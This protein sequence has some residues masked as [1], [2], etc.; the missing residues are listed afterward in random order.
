MTPRRLSPL[1]LGLSVVAVGCAQ[2]PDPFAAPASPAMQLHYPTGLALHPTEPILFVANSNFDLAYSSGAVLGVHL[3]WLVQTLNAQDRVDGDIKAPFGAAAL[4]PSIG[5][6]LVVSL[7]GK[8]LFHTTRQDNKLV[9]LTV[10]AREDGVTL[11]CV[12]GAGDP[13]DCT[14]GPH[15]YKF[16]TNDPYGMVVRGDGDQWNVLVSA[17]RDGQIFSLSL[18]PKV[19]G[20]GRLSHRWDHRVGDNARGASLALL[21]SVDGQ[22]EYLYAT[23]RLVPTDVPEYAHVDY[24]DLWQGPDAP[25]LT[26]DLEGGEPAVGAAVDLRDEI[27]A[28]D[29]RGIAISPSRQR[30]Y[31]I[32]KLPAAVVELDVSRRPDG[33][34]YNTVTRVSQVGRE[35]SCIALYEPAVGRPLILTAS[36]R[37][38][39][40]I[41]L[42]MDTLDVVRALR[43]VGQGPFDI[44]VDSARGYAYVSN[45]DDDTVA[46]VRL[47]H[48][49]E[50]PRIMVAARLGQP[51]ES[52]QTN[53]DLPFQ[54]GTFVPTTPEIPGGAP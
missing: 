7:D 18:D 32:T 8:H 25:V 9:E 24:M 36:F 31:V 15:T 35:P 26:V 33:R 16:N 28:I 38:D 27:G 48:S 46:V 39:V 13:P 2:C 42:D 53:P 54:D 29:A 34:P 43:D 47:P 40:L 14:T 6:P 52:A 45:F 50:D 23:S 12:D 44:A 51:R 5:G 22:P 10:D 19:D 21:P 41:V 49:L 1:F 11:G 17:I 4:V 3:G 37:D 30:A 20:S